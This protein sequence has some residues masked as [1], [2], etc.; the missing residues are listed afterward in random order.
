M[1]NGF[2]ESDV[3]GLG[4][5]LCAAECI[6][7]RDQSASASGLLP[8]FCRYSTLKFC[9]MQAEIIRRYKKPGDFI[10]TNGMF[11]NVDNHRMEKECLDV[12]T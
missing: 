3:Y 2:L 7:Q 8:L 5:G 1:G 11:W 10:T 12:Y 6:E 9:G 4:G